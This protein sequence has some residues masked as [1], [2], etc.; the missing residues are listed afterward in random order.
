MNGLDGVLKPESQGWRRL[1]A[2]EQQQKWLAGS[3][4]ENCSQEPE[5]AEGNR[6]VEE[7]ICCHL[8]S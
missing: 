5:R 7:L 1:K 6:I 2:R 8:Q 3:K 4:P